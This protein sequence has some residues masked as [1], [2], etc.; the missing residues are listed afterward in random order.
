MYNLD[1]GCLHA[2]EDEAQE[3]E[4][5]VAMVG[6]KVSHHSLAQLPEVAWLG[7][8]P[9]VNEGHPGSHGKAAALEPLLGDAAGDAFG[10]P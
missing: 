6:V 3:D 8:L 9:L 5:V 7:E 10:E 4:N 2:V 1:I